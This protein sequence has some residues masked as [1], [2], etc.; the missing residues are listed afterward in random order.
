MKRYIFLII[1]LTFTLLYAV[2]YNVATGNNVK[3]SVRDTLFYYHANTDDQHWFGSDV[4]AVKFEFNELFEEIDS[5]SFEAEGANIFIP[6]ISGTDDLIVKLC[7][8]RAGQPLTHQDSLLDVQTLQESEIQYQGWNYIPFSN[9]I[10]DTTLWLVVEYPTNSFEQFISASALGGLQSYFFDDGYFYNMFSISF[11][12]EFLFSLQ[13]RILSVGTDLDL[14]SVDWEGEILSSGLIYPKFTVKNNSNF[15]VASS[16]ISSLLEDPNNSLELMYAADSTICQQIDLPVL[17]ANELYMF[18]FSDSL[19]YILP[20]RASQYKFEA[21]LFCLTDSLTQNNLIEDEFNIYNDIKENVFIENTVQL[22]DSN[23]NNIWLDQDSILDTSNCIIVNY[24]A[25]FIDE[26]FFNDDS[27]ARYHFY[28]LMGF[29]ATIVDGNKKMLGYNSNYSSKLTDFYNTALSNSTFISS[30]TCFASFN[31]MGNV[32]FSYALENSFTQL[33]SEFVNDLTLRIGIIEN[34]VNE[35]GIPADLTLPVFTFLVA[36]INATQ[37]LDSNT[38]TDTVLFNMYDDFTTIT[39]D[40]DNCE[41]VLWLQNDESREIFYAY[42][43]PFTEFQPGLVSLEEDEIPITT[44]NL[45]IFPNP[46]KTDE[47]MNI[48]FSISKTMQSI[49]LR[50]YNIKG[51]LVKTISQEPESQNVSFIWDGKNSMKK[52]VSSGIYLMQINTKINGK[53]YKFHKKSLLLR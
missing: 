46:C 29:P 37:L 45:N 5:L 11:D 28:D 35:P 9:T 8:D 32:G 31:E 50:I 15:P 34:V 21:E 18:D 4:W 49:E 36:E 1:L 19:V 17:E 26:P 38:I 44:H 14:V 24:F 47:M 27:Y 23:S 20:D 2:E 41:V 16:Y 51:Q 43:L 33:F 52:Q 53:E 30:D 10:T 39:G 7:E 3:S 48:S 40:F 13:G 12:S 42:K 6:G 25:N 22:N